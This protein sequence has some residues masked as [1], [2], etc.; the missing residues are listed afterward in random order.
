MMLVGRGRGALPF[1]AAD[2]EGAPFAGAQFDAVI[3][4]WLVR[5]VADL[6][7]VLAE[8]FR[9][10]CPGGRVVI[11]DTTRPT[12]NLLTPFIWLYMHLGIPLLG[13]LVS[14]NHEAYQYLQQSSEGFLLAEELATRMVKAG[15]SD[16]GF[17]RYMAGTIA[18][19]W[20][21]KLRQG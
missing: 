3:S 5:N 9:L 4:G 1:V 17:K 15:F 10:L 16:V 6:D 19:H 18:I 13:R 14:H 8:I 2:A 7:A 11:L 12:R 20:A 21:N